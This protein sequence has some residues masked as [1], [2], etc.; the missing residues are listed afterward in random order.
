[1]EGSWSRAWKEIGWFLPPCPHISYTVAHVQCLGGCLITVTH[2]CGWTP[3][4]GSES[5][6]VQGTPGMPS[7]ILWKTMKLLLWIM[8][9]ISF[10]VRPWARAHFRCEDKQW[11]L[12]KCSESVFVYWRIKGLAQLTQCEKWLVVILPTLENLHLLLGTKAMGKMSK[13]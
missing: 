3:H 10:S 1:M 13:I 9:A 8:A 4:D 12:S 2:R 6:L 11:A 7:S 5:Q